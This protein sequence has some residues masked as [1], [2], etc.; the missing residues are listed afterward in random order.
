MRYFF[1]LFA[2]FIT[3][4]ISNLVFSDDQLT[5]SQAITFLTSEVIEPNEYLDYYSAFG[6]Q[7]ILSV[8][9]YVKSGGPEYIIKFIDGEEV[10][11]LIE[12]EVY[13]ISEP[14][15]FFFVDTNKWAK[16]THKAYY[17]YIDATNLNPTIGNGIVVNEHHWYPNING[18]DYLGTVQ[19]RMITEDRCYGTFP[20]TPPTLP[21][22]SD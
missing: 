6:P 19:E 22:P 17:V 7:E 16:W 4:I 15:W 10:R 21:L 14:T 18:I 11:S 8:G 5:R 13:N 1:I 2:I 3:T 12:K 9:D 20:T